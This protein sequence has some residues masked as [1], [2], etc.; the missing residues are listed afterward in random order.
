[1]LLTKLKSLPVCWSAKLIL[2]TL[3]VSG[4]GS[5]CGHRDSRLFWTDGQWIRDSSGRVFIS[6]GLNLSDDNKF[7]SPVTGEFIPNWFNADC[8]AEIASWGFNTVRFVMTWEGLEPEPG[9]YNE[10]YL[11]RLEQAAEWARA[12]GI[13]LIFDMHQDLYA[14]KFHGDGAPEWAVLDEGLYFLPLGNGVSPSLWYLNYTSPAVEK[15][16]DNFYGDTN[17]IQDHFIEAW[18]RVAER[19]PG[20]PAV[21]GYDLLN[22]PFP[23]SRLLQ[24]DDFDRDYFQPFYEKLIS[25]L[26]QVDSDH[27]FFLE[28]DAM[29]TNFLGES[30]FPSGFSKFPIAQD[31]LV[32]APHFYDPDVTVTLDYDGDISRLEKTMDSL[33]QEARRLQVPIWVGEWG[34]WGGAAGHGEKFLADQL[35]VYDQYLASD[36]YWDYSRNPTDTASPVNSTW[37]QENLIRP[38][39]SFIAGIPTALNYDV[40]A[41]KFELKFTEEKAGLASEIIVPTRFCQPGDCRVEMEPVRSNSWEAGKSQGVNI[42]KV[43]SNSKGTEFTIRIS[44]D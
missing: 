24:L 18:R 8:F 35:T 25:S 33:V 20:N 16:F 17:G 12:A 37:I 39:P 32:F 36:S 9:Q 43:L 5:G 7:P 30:G 28:P 31:K 41:G 1:M 27:L 21:V 6:R 44:K 4:L 11:G 40:A 3:V 34:L 2:L 29:R 13:Y 22:E 23:G 42:L 26:L 10:Q 14:R 15:A 38:Q 19:F